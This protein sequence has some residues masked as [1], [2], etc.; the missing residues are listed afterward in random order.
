MPRR[1]ALA[2]RG[3]IRAQ[4]ELALKATPLK[5]AMC[6][7]DLVEGDSL[8]DRASARQPARFSS[9]DSVGWLI[10]SAPVSGHRPTAI[11]KAGSVRSASTSSQSS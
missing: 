3:Q 10:S 9:R 4:D 7:G 5:P 8:G 2:S 6:L 11:F 1:S